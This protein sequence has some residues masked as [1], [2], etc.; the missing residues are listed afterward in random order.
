MA[1]SITNIFL[2]KKVGGELVKNIGL[3]VFVNGLYGISDGTI[4]IFNIVDIL[5]GIVAMAIG[6]ILER[7]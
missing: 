2:D 3:G 4:E 1:K 7:N 6:I 5:V